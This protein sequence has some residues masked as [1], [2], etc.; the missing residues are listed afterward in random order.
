MENTPRLAQC[1]FSIHEAL[2]SIPSTIR[3]KPKPNNN[4]M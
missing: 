3:M 2:G 1:M 4:K